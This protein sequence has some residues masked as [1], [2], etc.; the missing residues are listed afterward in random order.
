MSRAAFGLGLNS[1]AKDT[2][3]LYKESANVTPLHS[4]EKPQ[5][6]EQ[7]L[8]MAARNDASRKQVMKDF[9]AKSRENLMK[10]N[11]EWMDQIIQKPT[12][13]E[14]MTFFWHGHFACRTLVPWFAQRLNNTIRT[15]AL[16]SFRELL[17]AV[18]REPAML[19]FLNNQQNKKDHPNENFARE[20]MELFTLGRGN[21]S[22]LDV[23]EAARAFTGW[24]FNFAGEF[25]FR[26]KQ[27]DNDIKTFRGN[28]GNYNGEDILESIL[29]DPITA[30]FITAKLYRFF[31][32]DQPASPEVVKTW[33]DSF[34]SS[35]YNLSKLLHI[36]FQ[37]DEFNDPVN[38]GNR[39][40]SPIELLL[41]FQMHT[42]STFE[43]PQSQIFLQRALGQ[44]AF[45]PPNVSGWPSGRAWIDSS[46]LT[47]RI[48]LPQL[49][50]VAPKQTLKQVMTEMPTGSAKQGLAKGV[51]AARR[52]G[53]SSPSSLQNH[54]SKRRLIW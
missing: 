39:I 48:A 40:K 22:E 20:V 8:R 15:M 21:Y 35:D 38:Q 34:Y 32:S 24:G 42:G 3:T 10:V 13:R 4:V 47:F 12:L 16:G 29:E 2:E 50:F 23:K 25:Q 41:G 14:R 46:S 31:I 33:A 9:L 7:S 53:P 6:D 30:R 43:N 5:W 49:L 44:I 36:I 1:N 18:S 37:S 26:A 45:Y 52:I 27:H 11:L 19:Q 54:H 28:S 51:C 17:M